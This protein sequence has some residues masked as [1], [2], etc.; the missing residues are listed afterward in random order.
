MRL[1]RLVCCVLGM[2]SRHDLNK[3]VHNLHANFVQIVKIGRRK[4]WYISKGRKQEVLSM[5]VQETANR[6]HMKPPAEVKDSGRYAFWLKTEEKRLMLTV[7]SM[8]CVVAMRRSGFRR[9]TA[10]VLTR[11]SSGFLRTI[12]A[13]QPTPYFSR[14][15]A[16]SGGAR[17]VDRQSLP[18]C[19][20]LGSGRS[21]ESC[22]RA[23]GG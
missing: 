1:V 10:G 15:S 14:A 19:I 6:F 16:R 18:P 12:R 3:R 5:S 2:A 17:I 4:L 23:A 21:I 9:V 7:W 20:W 13:A 8:N 11:G 22:R